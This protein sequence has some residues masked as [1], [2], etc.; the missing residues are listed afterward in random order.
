MITKKITLILILLML[1]MP[2][3]DA[4]WGFA[5]KST[6][7]IAKIAVNPKTF[8]DDEII[9]LSKLTDETKGTAKI[10]KKL[11]KLKL[12]N[13]VL[14]DTYMRIAIHQNK[15]SRKEAEGMFSRLS[16]TPGFGTTLR[17]IIGNSDKVTTGHLNELRIADS[18]S[19]YGFTVLGIGETFRD[20]K[21]K[22]PTDID[23]VL[24][25]GIKYF[26]IEAKN[27]ASTTIIPMDKYRADL[28]TLVAY[29]NKHTDDLITIFSITNKPDYPRQLWML[30]HEANK[31]NV[32]LIFGSPQEQVEKI[33]LLGKIL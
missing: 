10:G 25:K 4:F 15:I 27:N 30:K 21:K 5:A 6:S 9:R 8:P 20:G 16:D 12:P 23:I 26:A 3:A 22:A 33:K 1:A 7:K 2:H 24:K 28:D 19:M 13:D 31:R 11:G 17:K 32:Q 18:A 29:K 14:E